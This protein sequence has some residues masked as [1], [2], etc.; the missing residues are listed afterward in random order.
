[1]CIS[2]WE[3]ASLVGWFTVAGFE[4][5]WHLKEPTLFS[6]VLKFISNV[7]WRGEKGKKTIEKKERITAEEWVSTIIYKV[8]LTELVS[9]VRY[10]LG[11]QDPI[12][13]W[14]S[15]SCNQF[16]NQSI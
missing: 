11:H 8:H 4:C 14:N 16:H 9:R 2:N 3:P 6:A 13:N 5:D 10:D 15:L 7:L 1:M 12:Q